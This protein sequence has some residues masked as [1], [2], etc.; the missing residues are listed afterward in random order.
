MWAIFYFFIT[1]LHYILHVVLFC[2]FYST[3]FVWYLELLVTLSLCVN[4]QIND[5]KTLTPDH[6]MQS[7]W[8]V[9]NE[10]HPAATTAD[11]NFS[12]LL[13][14]IQWCNIIWKG[15]FCIMSTFTFGTLNVFWWVFLQCCSIAILTSEHDQ[16][17][18]PLPNFIR[19]QLEVEQIKMWERNKTINLWLCELKD[20]ELQNGVKKVYSLSPSVLP[21]LPPPPPL[22]Q[23]R[24][25]L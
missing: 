12:A 7:R 25:K 17:T 24:V 18:C 6:E 5:D 9:W 2:T 19:L 15:T 23:I 13:F 4:K 16:S 21:P 14:I 11:V 3:I 1:V 20:A 10:F 22:H 8:G